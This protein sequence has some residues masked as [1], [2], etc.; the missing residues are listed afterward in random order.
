MS[1]N[2]CHSLAAPFPKRVQL[3]ICIFKMKNLILYLKPT[4]HN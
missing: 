2:V 1:F 4:D 3:L